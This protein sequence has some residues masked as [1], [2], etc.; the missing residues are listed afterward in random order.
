MPLGGQLG[1]QL[2]ERVRL[3]LVEARAGLVEQQELGPDGQGPG[4]LDHPGQ[5]GGHGRR[6]LRSPSPPSPTPSSSRSQVAIRVRDPVRVSASA[7][8]VVGRPAGRRRRT[9]RPRLC[10]CPPLELS[11]RDRP[12]RSPPADSEPNSSRRWKVRARP[13]RARW[14]GFMPVTSVSNSWTVPRSGGL[15]PADDV[16]QRGL[17]GAVGTDQPG[18]RPRLHGEADI[19]EGGD[20][21][22]PDG[23]LR[24]GQ[25]GAVA[26]GCCHGTVCGRSFS[27]RHGSHLRT[28]PRR[29][30]RPAPACRPPTPAV[31][32]AGGSGW[33]RSRGCRP[34]PGRS[35]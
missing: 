23:D 21:A 8:P 22:E 32:T 15:Q 25:D 12:G 17:A 19:A 9:S 14:W 18:D 5:T 11:T 13:S 7:P 4:Q 35:G 33:P 29:A 27:R 10:H 34:R 20:P 3:D 31:P 30:G 16:E 24:H 28:R 2:P 26:G 1:Q 6:V